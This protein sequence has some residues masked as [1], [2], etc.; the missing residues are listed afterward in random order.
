MQ[1]QRVTQEATVHSPGIKPG[2]EGA[3]VLLTTDAFPESEEQY[4]SSF[5]LL[6]FF[7]KKQ[8]Q[9]CH[10]RQGTQPVV[11]ASRTFETAQLPGRECCFSPRVTRLSVKLWDLCIRHVSNV[12]APLTQPW[13]N[14]DCK[15]HCVNL[16]GTS[17]MC[18]K[19]AAFTKASNC[20]PWLWFFSG[21]GMR[22]RKFPTCHFKTKERLSLFPPEN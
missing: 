10:P 16:V 15:K 18:Q 17:L 20:R 4:K 1:V 22:G 6:S 19:A 3:E 8:E 13:T 5:K 11:S 12:A 9:N 14:V 21:T 2:G 7:S